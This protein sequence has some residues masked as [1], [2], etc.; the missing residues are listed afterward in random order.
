MTDHPGVAR[1]PAAVLFDLYGTL[2]P[3]GSRAERDA[4]SYDIAAELGVDAVEFADLVRATFDD[5][6]RGV[7]GDLAATYRELAARLGGAPGAEAAGRAVE[8]RRC[9]AQGYLESCRVLDV[10]AAVRA[11]GVRIGLVTDCSAETVD[12]WPAGPIAPLVDEAA[13]SCVIGVR[14]PDPRIYRHV[15]DRLGLPGDRCVYVGDGGSCELSGA[16]ALGMLP[17][18]C[19]EY[20]DPG[21]ERPDAEPDWRG[22]RITRLRD[23]LPWLAVA[24]AGDDVTPDDGG[25]G[26]ARATPGAGDR[27]GTCTPADRS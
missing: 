8:R 23:L 27:G 25:T 26:A 12:A 18:L 9:A 3:G 11:G 10:L 22:L 20:D 19:L 17:M 21:T 15:L 24:S 7:L 1:P 14:K 16:G 13:F 6:V 5:R 4:V 2:V